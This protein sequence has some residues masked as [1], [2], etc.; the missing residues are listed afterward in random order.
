MWCRPASFAELV[1]DSLTRYRNRAIETAQ[2][3]EQP[4]R[5]RRGI[6]KQRELMY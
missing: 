6:L 3:I 2:A 5:K 1:Q 4:R